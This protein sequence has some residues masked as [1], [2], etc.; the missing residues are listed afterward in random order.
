MNE[1]QNDVPTLTLTPN[2]T[3]EVNQTPK[4]TE[5]ENAASN[6]SPQ[7]QKMVIS[8][9]KQIDITDSA[10]IMNYGAGTQQKM[11]GFADKTL[12]KVQTSDTGAIGDML[13]ELVM[14]LK[15]FDAQEEKKGFLG[16]FKKAS[17]KLETLKI[18]YDKV[19]SNVTTITQ[20][21]EKHQVQLLKDISVLDQ[22][23]DMNLSY[24]KELTMYIEAG[25]RKIEDVKTNELAALRL[26][27][28]QS[29][30]AEDAQA[31]NDLQ[32]QIDR[33]EK[34]ISDLDITRMI[35]I[36]TAPQ[37]RLVQNN[38]SMLAEKIQST[39]VN[40]IPLW[41]NQMLLALGLSHSQQALSA[42]QAVSN[43]TNELLK[44]NAAALK[45]ST[46]ETAKESQR[47][48]VDIE[49]LNETNASLIA[50]LDEVMKIQTEGRE[51]RAAAETELRRME[52]EVKAK[53]LELK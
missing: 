8:F 19:E 4:P 3:N 29:G 34:K 2:L 14:E 10:Q 52:N 48:I 50:T 13:T 45:Q 41:K 42:Q 23:Y 28:Q 33:F 26:K 18:K 27:A 32:S 12:E 40:T 36:Q 22:M 51:K 35:S 53:L 38:N 47:S 25:K 30:L 16:L 39:L 21:L 5:A 43:M 20:T 1:L 11:A 44:K 17:G 24:L 6:L 7:E 37:I 15:N 31:A 46:I 49:T 9:A